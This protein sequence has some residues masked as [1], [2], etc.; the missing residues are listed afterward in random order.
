[1]FVGA[2]SGVVV[3]VEMVRGGVALL[4]RHMGR[5]HASHG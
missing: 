3:A 5:G 1:V 4:K 2:V